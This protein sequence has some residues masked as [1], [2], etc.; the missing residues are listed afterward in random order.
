[1]N[2]RLI[3]VTLMNNVTRLT[4]LRSD[5]SLQQVVRANIL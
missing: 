3:I 5:L 4:I 1:M 2:E